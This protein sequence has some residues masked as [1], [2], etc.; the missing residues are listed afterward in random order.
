MSVTIGP[1]VGNENQS[2]QFLCKSNVGIP[3]LT[4][5]GFEKKPVIYALAAPDFSLEIRQVYLLNPSTVKPEELRF[6]HQITLATKANRYPEWQNSLAL[7]QQ[8]ALPLNKLHALELA[9]ITK[10][11]QWLA[12]DFDS[13]FKA[14]NLVGE[15]VL[16][17]ILLPVFWVYSGWQTGIR[18][19]LLVTIAAESTHIAKA[20]FA[21]PRP[22]HLMPDLQRMNAH[23]FGM[24]SGHVLVATVFWGY[25]W[26]LLKPNLSL[27]KQH[28]TLA[29]LI[30]LLL[31]CAAARVYWGVH[32][33]TDVV[34]GAVFGLLILSAFIHFD[35]TGLWQRTLFTKKMPW[36]LGMT[37][38]AIT[39]F[40]T[41]DALPCQLSGLM[42]GILCGLHLG[43]T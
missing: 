41:P 33:I 1:Q 26:Y 10:F 16:F 23:G 3:I 14:F 19:T 17:F 15:Y 5:Q 37:A 28:F 4:R 22:F 29:S 9:G 38:I 21:L 35:K 20:T 36:L 34:A 43:K 32:F 25:C 6:P 39:I 13:I 42:L 12:P 31:G 24:P 27:P 18:L 7:M 11:Q 2:A 40:Y 30:V 8:N